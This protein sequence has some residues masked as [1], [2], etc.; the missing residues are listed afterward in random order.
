MMVIR[1]KGNNRRT[2]LRAWDT[3]EMAVVVASKSRL[4]VRIHVMDIIVLG[5]RGIEV[6]IKKLPIVVIMGFWVRLGRSPS[7][8]AAR[9]WGGQYKIFSPRLY[10]HLSEH[11]KWRGDNRQRMD[12]S[13]TSRE[14]EKR[15]R[16]IERDKIIFLGR[17]GC[18]IVIISGI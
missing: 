2:R 16:E 17:W 14:K 10:R 5:G 4:S 11:E 12:A 9:S 15:E 3:R 6:V 1:G 18:A 13:K 7:I 8:L